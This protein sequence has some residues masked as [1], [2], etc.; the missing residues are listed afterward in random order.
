MTTTP[1]YSV[2]V[3]NQWVGSP[4]DSLTERPQFRAVI[5][6]LDEARALARMHNG[7]VMVSPSDWRALPTVEVAS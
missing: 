1:R 4:T 5:E 6:S 2:K 3:G 7:I